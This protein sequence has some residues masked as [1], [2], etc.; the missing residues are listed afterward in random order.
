MRLTAALCLIVATALPV[1]A[2]TA[3]YSGTL[4]KA[5]IVVELTEDLGQTDAAPAGRYLYLSKGVDIPLQRVSRTGDTVIL[6]EEE[7]CPADRCGEGEAAPIA[8]RWTLTLSEDGNRLTGTWADKRTLPIA[9][10]LDA[11]AASDAMTPLDL[12]QRSDRLTYGEAA[13]ITPTTSPYDVLRLDV[14][15]GEGPVEGWPG[16]QWRMVHDPRTKFPSPRIVTVAGGPADRANAVLEQ[17]HWRDSLSAFSCAAL[18]YAGFNEFGTHPSTDDGTLGAWDETSAEVQALTPTLLSWRESGS[19]YCG[20]AHPAN[21][22]NA[23]VM[24][25][26]TGRILSLADMF[27]DVV[28]G[29]PGPSLKAFIAEKR[30]TPTNPVDLDYETECGIPELIVEYLAASLVRDGDA[31]SVVFGLQNLPHAINACGDDVLTLPVA[32]VAALMTPA[33]AAL[34]GR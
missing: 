10:T 18:Q 16:A 5:A 11:V 34:V 3:V 8:A 20:G 17:R 12:Y 19:L 26:R 6:A 21:Y 24:E 29:K 31:L 1:W 32:D 22:S 7:P 33:F 25:V 2:D 9:L 14:T 28:D 4:G 30:G 23:Y 13:D 15:L 27:T